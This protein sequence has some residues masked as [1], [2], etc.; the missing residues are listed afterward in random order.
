M[1]IDELLDLLQRF[2]LTLIIASRL[3]RELDGNVISSYDAIPCGSS[4]DGILLTTMATTTSWFKFKST[5]RLIASTEHQSG[6][7]K[8]KTPC[9]SIYAR[10]DASTTVWPERCAKCFDWL[11]QNQPTLPLV[12]MAPHRLTLSLIPLKTTRSYILL[13][14]LPTH[15]AV[16][17]SGAESSRNS[18]GAK[19][20][21]FFPHVSRRPV[22]RSKNKLVETHSFKNENTR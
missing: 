6:E 10:S 18:T 2:K 17:G 1:P 9:V 13:L 8:K 4:I 7:R 21:V 12:Q 22:R 3:D 15:I 11:T 14:T 19:I 16:D 20:Y 5:L